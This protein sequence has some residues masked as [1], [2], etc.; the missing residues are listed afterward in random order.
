MN[1]RA[2]ASTQAHVEE[3]AEKANEGQLSSV[4]QRQYDRYLEA[5]R[6]VT[7]LQAKARTF[8]ESQA[9]HAQN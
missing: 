6:F 3:L 1:L 4:E 5:F 2:D 9:G 8:L 7:I